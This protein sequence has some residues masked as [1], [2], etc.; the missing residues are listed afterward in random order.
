MGFVDEALPQLLPS[1]RDIV[2]QYYLS[3]ETAYELMLIA[4][5]ADNFDEFAHI[6]DIFNLEV[7]HIREFAKFVS[8]EVDPRD[9][10]N[11][12]LEWLVVNSGTD[13]RYARWVQYCHLIDVQTHLNMVGYVSIITSMV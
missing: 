3:K 11:K 4:F 8:R 2:Y 6:V 1:L 7:P 10:L 13:R 9:H 5:K 12:I